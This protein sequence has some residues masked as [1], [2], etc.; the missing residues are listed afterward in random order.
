[1]SDE[2]ER[3]QRAAKDMQRVV[4]R[5]RYWHEVMESLSGFAA[6]TLEEVLETDS[7]PNPST[8][9][10]F[11]NETWMPLT[12]AHFVDAIQADGS[13]QKKAYETSV[14]H[15]KSRKVA[16]DIGANIGLWARSMMVD[17]ETV[18]CFEPQSIARACLA[19]NADANNVVI[20]PFA[21][22]AEAGETVINVNRLAGGGAMIKLT[23][24][25]ES[26]L[27]SK[28]PSSKQDIRVVTLDSMGL[29]PDYIKIDV[30]G[31]EAE[32][33]LGAKQ[34]IATHKPTIICEAGG[35]VDKI[36]GVDPS[37]AIDLILELGYEQVDKVGKDVVLNAI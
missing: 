16:I 37:I 35:Q 22:G 10:K 29:A 11:R 20:F 21:V 19:R 36:S 18:Y 13:Y 1:M 17:F 15:T 7:S 2:I 23:E 24:E 12:E 30:Q 8:L 5:F 25:T 32:V 27:Q 4:D 31:F 33:I 26:A 14:K 28:F 9:M 6:N 3:I 34:T